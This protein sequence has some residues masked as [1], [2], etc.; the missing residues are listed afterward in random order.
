MPR[1]QRDACRKGRLPAALWGGLHAAAAG[2]ALGLILASCAT[3]SGAARESAFRDGKPPAYPTACFIVV[4]D[5]HLYDPAAF[6]EEGALGTKEERESPDP[7]LP[8]PSAEILD[9]AL[10]SISGIAAD[11]VLFTGD[12]S[13]DGERADHLAF[14][15]RLEKIRASGKR[16]YV[17]PGNHDVNVGAARY[18]YRGAAMGAHSIGPEEFAKIYADF[19]YGDA[20]SRAPDSLSYEARPL[21]GLTLLALDDSRWRENRPSLE[22]INSGRLTSATRAWLESRLSAAA[23]EGRA[24]IVMQHHEVLE[25]WRGQ[26]LLHPE[27]LVEGSAELARLYARLGAR[28]V[29]TGHYHAQDATLLRRADGSFVCDATTSS[30][31]YYPCAFRLVKIEGGRASF[32]SLFV[33]SIPSQPELFLEKART[34]ARAGAEAEAEITFERKGFWP[35][36]A[37]SLAKRAATDFLG[38]YPGSGERAID[39]LWS[40]SEPLAPFAL[41][42][43]LGIMAN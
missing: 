9:D 7:C 20:A 28:L 32:E 2:L 34:A 39:R 25:H 5:P 8:G 37:S 14:A 15:R 35:A 6:D 1:S 23:A 43:S 40:Q 41:D 10:A 18:Y 17:V 24:V 27:Y 19:G 36:L 11:F 29:F 16:V 22:P 12:L 30:L 4:S 3:W 33:D 13:L 38:H 31:V 26:R 21:P 42:L